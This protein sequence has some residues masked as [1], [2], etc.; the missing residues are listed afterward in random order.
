MR[1]ELTKRADYAMR[2]MLALA[3]TELGER[4]SVREIAQDQRIPARFLPQAMTDLIRAGLVDATV[5]RRGGYRLARSAASISLLEVVEAIEGDS[6]RRVCILRGGPCALEGVCDVHE[7]FAAAQEDV[8]DRLRSA[9]VA[10]A[11]AHSPGGYG[12]DR[13][14]PGSRKAA[15]PGQP[16]C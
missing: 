13:I 1:L 7:I 2:A 6:R 5:G 3:R 14:G 11:I 10:D 9:T 8:I 12:P 4:R 16:R 15:I